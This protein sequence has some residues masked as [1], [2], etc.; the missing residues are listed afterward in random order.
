MKVN[1]DNLGKIIDELILFINE[2][3]S[4]G[5][6]ICLI[7]LLDKKYKF[8]KIEEVMDSECIITLES[9]YIYENITIPDKLL[10]EMMYQ[11]ILKAEENNIE[12]DSSKY[13]DQ[14]VGL[15]YNIPFIIKK[16]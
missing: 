6:E 12:L 7:E 16:N 15:P 8:L 5:T 3:V 2:K 14:K 9:N 13:Y 4:N 10:F 11:L 1:E